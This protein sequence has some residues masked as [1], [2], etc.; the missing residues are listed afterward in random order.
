[1]ADNKAAPT[2]ILPRS[3]SHD[4][5][6]ALTTIMAITGSSMALAI[7]VSLEKMIDKSYHVHFK[8]KETE[9]FR[10]W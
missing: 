10:G 3:R 7:H 6:Q 1:M 9:V 2:R 4:A 8:D 5:T